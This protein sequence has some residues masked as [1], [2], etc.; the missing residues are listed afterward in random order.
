VVA[1]FLANWWVMNNL[2]ATWHHENPDVVD[3]LTQAHSQLV[4]LPG[5]EAVLA[6]V[7]AALLE[8]AMADS[9]QSAVG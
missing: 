3:H 5:L 7:D 1:G 2:F 9:Q 6:L 8:L 4:D